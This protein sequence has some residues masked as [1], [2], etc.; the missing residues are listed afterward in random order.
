MAKLIG[1]NRKVEY[2]E[3]SNTIRLMPENYL[4]MVQHNSRWLF[5]FDAAVPAKIVTGLS[6]LLHKAMLVRYSPDRT[7]ARKLSTFDGKFYNVE[8]LVFDDTLQTKTWKKVSPTGGEPYIWDEEGARHH[9]K[10][11][12]GPL[13]CNGEYRIS[14]VAR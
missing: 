9:V 5:D 14:E 6:L 3:Y 2:C 10:T 4:L 8:V 13:A 11:Y 12:Q 1:E 7:L